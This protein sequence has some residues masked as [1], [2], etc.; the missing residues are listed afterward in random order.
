MWKSVIIL[1]CVHGA[2]G[3]RGV[4]K[5][6]PEEEEEELDAVCEDYS[7]EEVDSETLDITTFA[8]RGFCHCMPY[9]LSERRV[10]EAG[11]HMNTHEMADD[12]FF[13]NLGKKKIT[14]KGDKEWT[15]EDEGGRISQIGMKKTKKK[16]VEFE[17]AFADAVGL[18][19]KSCSELEYMA[20]STTPVKS[21]PEEMRN[22]YHDVKKR[23]HKQQGIKND[24]KDF[25]DLLTA[26]NA[27][28]DDYCRRPGICTPCRV[29]SE[30]AGDVHVCAP[31]DKEG[32]KYCAENKEI[33]QC[34]AM[35]KTFKEKKTCRA[36]GEEDECDANACKADDKFGKLGKI[37]FPK[38]PP[39]P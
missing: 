4:S 34:G 1:L 33:L 21:F 16:I 15:D 3:L 7:K 30:G 36:D 28:F 11:S 2:V 22:I 12:F 32:K 5:D 23:F 25:K 17:F 38:K 35:E 10:S 29:A 27:Y 24:R 31:V 26:Y 19:K 37:N 18:A 39:S 9:L 14:H 13:G 20:S 8:C 6:D